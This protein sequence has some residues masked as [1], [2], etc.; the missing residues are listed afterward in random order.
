MD[1]VTAFM[2]QVVI[3]KGKST[4]STTDDQEKMMIQKEEEKAKERAKTVSIT[5]ASTASAASLFSG[6]LNSIF[7]F[8]NT[9]EMLYAVYFYN[10]DLYS[11]F[12]EF[13][14]GLRVHS[15]MPNLFKL[16]LHEHHGINLPE[17]FHKYGFKTNLIFLNCGIQISMT[18][19]FIFILLVL[20]CLNKIKKI[21]KIIS[22]VLIFF[23]FGIFLRLLVQSYFDALTSC[24]IGL[25]FNDFS[26]F[27]Q[28]FNF[29]ICLLVSVFYI[30]I[31]LLGSVFAAVFILK[32]FNTVKDD[33]ERLEV[34]KSRFSIIFVEFKDGTSG[35]Y[36]FYL[37][38]MIRRIFILLMIA[39]EVNQFLQL[40]ISAIM[41]LSVTFI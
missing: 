33:V 18:I 35:L 23:K 39:F 16:F 9:A 14:L 34:F 32:K 2:L 41:A 5:V 8:L 25:K 29:T 3:Y 36:L 11:P 22:K 31:F 6:D 20:L 21:E 19:F 26:T 24:Y 28:I 1:A 27:V 17:K 4:F 37:I 38:Y 7:T 15:S 12:T 13:I 30:Q 40:V 10:V